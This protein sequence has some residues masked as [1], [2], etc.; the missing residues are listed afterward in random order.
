MN[1]K[2][3]D[4]I[5]IYKKKAG[6]IGDTCEAMNINRSTFYDWQRKHADFKQAVIEAD[7]SKYDWVESQFFKRMQEGSD[8]ILIWYSKTKMKN[9]GYVERNEIA[10][11]EVNNLQ[12][13]NEAFEKAWEEEKND[14]KKNVE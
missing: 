10:H 3:K 5:A 4:F 13:L 11:Q 2:E 8:T 12:E 1:K 7:E 9:R 6:N 14:K